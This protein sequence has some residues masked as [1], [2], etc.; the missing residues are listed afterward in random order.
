[1]QTF[2]VRMSEENRFVRVPR[3]ASA[4]APVEIVIGEGYSGVWVPIIAADAPAPAFA[5]PRAELLADA[6]Y[7]SPRLDAGVVVSDGADGGLRPGDS[8]R[9][10]AGAPADTGAFERASG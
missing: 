10:D 2:R 4:D 7:G 8:Y 6:Y 9:I 5:G 1:G 3:T